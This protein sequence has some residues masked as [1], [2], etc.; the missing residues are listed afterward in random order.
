[1]YTVLVNGRRWDGYKTLRDAKKTR[2]TLRKNEL[3]KNAEI[4]IY[5]PK[6]G[7]H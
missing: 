7:K 6:G 5:G 2:N 4:T 3:F 1:M